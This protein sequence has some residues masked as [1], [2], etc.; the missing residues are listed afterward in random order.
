MPK[1]NRELLK[2]GAVPLPQG[3]LEKMEN[4]KEWLL[5][6]ASVNLA[7]KDLFERD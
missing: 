3:D 1:G 5:S 4:L 2:L 7:E 6:H